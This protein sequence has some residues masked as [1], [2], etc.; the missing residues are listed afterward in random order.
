VNA[1]GGGKRVGLGLDA[2]GSYTDA[3]LVDLASGAVL[4]WAKASTDPGD[5]GRGIARALAG[6]SADLLH[7]TR[8]VGRATTFATNAV[9]EG[10]GG[11]DGLVLI[12]YDR[13]PRLPGDPRLLS[14]SGGHDFLG[15]GV[16]G[17]R[18]RRPGARPR[19]LRRGPRGRRRCGPVLRA[20]PLPRAR[21][22]TTAWWNARL[23]R[24][25]PRL[26]RRAEEVLHGA[27]IDAPLL[28]VRG[29]GTH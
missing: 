3:A 4:A 14:L 12:G 5:P 6:L 8:R 15:G 20:K 2:G 13:P 23:L 21:R 24:I 29:D 7:R 26:L 25:I 18:P 27:G 1:S 22:A 11:R 19:G 10:R 9:V 16:R 17:P 28:V